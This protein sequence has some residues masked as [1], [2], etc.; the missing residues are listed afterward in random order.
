M[1]W[2]VVFS[3]IFLFLLKVSH[4]IDFLWRVTPNISKDVN[5]CYIW[6]FSERYWIP[7]GP[8]TW[9]LRYLLTLTTTRPVIENCCRSW[10]YVGVKRNPHRSHFSGKSKEEPTSKFLHRKP[11]HGR[12]KAGRQSLSYFRPTQAT[13]DLIH[14]KWAESYWTAVRG[15]RGMTV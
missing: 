5:G 1:V 8:L 11:K 3:S 15:G 9:K 14:H 10:L 7:T 2:S 6:P 12:R 4:N 13:Q